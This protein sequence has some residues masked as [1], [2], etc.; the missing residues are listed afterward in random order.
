MAAQILP[1][2]FEALAM[3]LMLSS[4]NGAYRDRIVAAQAMQADAMHQLIQDTVCHAWL[5][6]RCFDFC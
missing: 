4:S 3:C 1:S 6:R 2:E 5:L